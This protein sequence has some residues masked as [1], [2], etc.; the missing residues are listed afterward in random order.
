MP[1]IYLI[2]FLGASVFWV[3]KKQF[4]K[5]TSIAVIGILLAFILA[6]MDMGTAE[7]NRIRKIIREEKGGREKVIAVLAETENETQEIMLHVASQSFCEN[8]LEKQKESLC[9]RLEEMI[10]GDNESLKHITKD[11][12]FPERV[13]GYPFFLSWSSS[14]P[15]I[16]SQEGII[17]E[18]IPVE[19]TEIE[20]RVEITEAS[21][22]YK[23][24]YSI[25][26]SVYPSTERKA[27]W[28]R[29]ERELSELE[30]ETRPDNEYILPEAFEDEQ[31]SFSIKKERKETGIFFLSIFIPVMLVWAEKEEKEKQKKKRFS[32]MEKEYPQMIVRMAM[33][34]DTG[35]TISGAFKRIAA[36]YGKSRQDK[37][38]PL[39]EEMLITCREIESGISEKSAYQNMGKRCRLNCITRFTAL[40]TQYTKSGSAGL[41]LALQ[42]EA[43]H[44]MKERKERTRKKG[45]E[46]GTKLLVPMMLMLV[47][48]MVM[49]MIPA[50][51]SFG[52]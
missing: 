4:R 15:K 6:V 26:G 23:S 51:T 21:A 49:I 25:Y 28:K 8:E 36:E 16:V 3:R 5:Y 34:A 39:F 13:E 24:E 29:L 32:L 11:L 19:G 35:M 44:A 9:N 20:L 10:I 22:N 50:F 46:A 30:A 43:E 2:S 33:L 47:L 48:V 42:E 52:M 1:V 12:V 41:K 27:F 40:L 7:E 14:N 18:N 45:E 31:I 38:K 37:E 17:G